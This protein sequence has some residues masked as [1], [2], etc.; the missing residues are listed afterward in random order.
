MDKKTI[1]DTLAI[2]KS[3]IERLGFNKIGLFGSYAK[4]TQ[5]SYS[6]IDIAIAKKS[7][8]FESAYDYFDKRQELQELLRRKLHRKIDIFD[9][10]SKS[11]IKHYIE[12]EIIY[13]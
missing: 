6:D 9:L 2:H 8:S 3:E 1:L 7:A 11:D 13:V 4:E 5:T 12:K 10:D